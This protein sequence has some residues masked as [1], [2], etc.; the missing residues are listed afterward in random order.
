MVTKPVTGVACGW[1]YKGGCCWEMKVIPFRLFML[2][3]IMSF[4]D[5]RHFH[6]FS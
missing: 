2:L 3:R 5:P 4:L 6:E 1:W